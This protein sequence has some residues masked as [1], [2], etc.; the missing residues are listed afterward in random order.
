[1]TQSELL[2]LQSRVPWLPATGAGR[3]LPL[4]VIVVAA[5]V[6]GSLV[7]AR[8]E[9]VEQRVLVSPRRRLHPALPAI[10]TAL[11]VV[12]VVVLHGAFRLA[13]VNSA[14][15]ALVCLSLVVVTGHLGELSLAQMAF[16]GIAG[17][18]LARVQQDLGV[19]FPVDAVVAVIA[20]TAAGVLVALPALRVRGPSL[21]VATL[22]AALA[23]Q[24]LVF[25]NPS[26]TGGFAGSRVHAPHV[27]T[28][29]GPGPG[30]A[31]YPR[32]QFAVVVVLLVAAAAWAVAQLR[33]RHV[34]GRLLAVRGNERAAAA[35]G[36][37]VTRTKVLGFAVSAALAGLAGVLIGWEQGRLSFGSFDVVASLGLVAVAYVGGIG[38]ITG[39][40]LGG[41]LAAGGIAFTALD[42]SAGGGRYQLL[43]TSVAVVVATV[44]APDGLT[45][46]GRRVRRLRARSPR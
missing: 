42:R 38:S 45:G 31:G 15:A 44:A 7:P 20:A 28:D 27:G 3:A 34:G 43:V 17:F 32:W 1:V 30:G 13:V 5:I 25:Q 4:L 22:A 10:A 16:A 23:A 18:V 29:L 21:A 8:G 36:I 24:A 37:S 2:D 46:A 6:R 9:V 33:R 11:A 35:A 12:T 14:V 26:L 41:A 19:P 40:V 39:A